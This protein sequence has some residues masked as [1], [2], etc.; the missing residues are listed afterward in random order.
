MNIANIGFQRQN[1]PYIVEA[2]IMT[3]DLVDIVWNSPKYA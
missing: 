3:F 1:T 2:I